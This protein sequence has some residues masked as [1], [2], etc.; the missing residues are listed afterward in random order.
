MDGVTDTQLRFMR[1]ILE[2]LDVINKNLEKI[3]NELTYSNDMKYKEK[4]D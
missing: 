2:R 1:S 3:A 4:Y